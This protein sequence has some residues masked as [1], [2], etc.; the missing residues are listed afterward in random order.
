M[1]I[2]STLAMPK[3][4]D[5]PTKKLIIRVDSVCEVSAFISCALVFIQLSALSPVSR[6]C[7]TTRS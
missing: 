5:S 6:S 4:T 3:A 7:S 2:D 1:L